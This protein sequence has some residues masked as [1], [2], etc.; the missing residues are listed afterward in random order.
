MARTWRPGGHIWH[1][2]SGYREKPRLCN[3][4]QLIQI[5]KYTFQSASA[6]ETRQSNPAMQEATLY[7]GPRS[8]PESKNRA[9]TS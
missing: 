6:A 3:F 8:G 1:D 7:N 9:I 5:I 4:L 2:E